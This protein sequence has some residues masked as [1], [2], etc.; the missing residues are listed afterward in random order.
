M[1]LNGQ[2]DL[3]ANK[4]SVAR[5]QTLELINLAVELLREKPWHERLIQHDAFNELARIIDLQNSRL[6]QLT[7]LVDYFN[8]FP[9]IIKLS[10]KK[11]TTSLDY[12]AINPK[13][14]FEFDQALLASVMMNLI[15]NAKK[16]SEDQLNPQIKLELSI[17]S[18]R[19]L[20][21]RLHI[22]LSNS[23]QFP[24]KF[25]AKAG[26]ARQTTKLETHEHGH[27]LRSATEKIKAH[28]GE[29]LTINNTKDQMAEI[30]FYIEEMD[31]DRPKY[32]KEI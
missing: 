17:E 2:S 18:P 29:G 22:K 24:E 16:A 23:G 20:P 13:D 15:A 11:I 32:P 19:G 26:R 6:T 7:T 4:L 5:L 21:R 1:I 14:K 25:I 10:N 3:T 12:K 28:G 8:H 27:G 30:S 31:G 9:K